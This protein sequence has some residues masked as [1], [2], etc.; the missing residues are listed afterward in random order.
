[1]KKIEALTFT[2]EEVESICKEYD[3]NAEPEYSGGNVFVNLMPEDSGTIIWMPFAEILAKVRPELHVDP[4]AIAIYDFG[5]VIFNSEEIACVV[6][7]V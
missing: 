5:N 7:N 2:D 3:K 6:M 4:R 1:M